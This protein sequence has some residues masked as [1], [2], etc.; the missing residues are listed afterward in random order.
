MSEPGTAQGLGAGSAVVGRCWNGL[1][2]GLTSVCTTDK[3]PQSLPGSCL[4]RKPDSCRYELPSW[5]PGRWSCLA[6][7]AACERTVHT[8]RVRQDHLHVTQMTAAMHA[9]QMTVARAD[10]RSVQQHEWHTTTH[11]Q[12]SEIRTGRKGKR[13]WIPLTSSAWNWS[14]LSCGCKREKPASAAA[15]TGRAKRAAPNRQVQ[16]TVV[17]LSAKK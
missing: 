7:P 2:L 4:E 5:L 9:K 14:M 10:A 3:P 11:C 6:L 16:Q 13:P 15:L 17:T 12:Q 1:D 8:S